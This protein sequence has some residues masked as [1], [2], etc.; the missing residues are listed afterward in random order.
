MIFLLNTRQRSPRSSRRSNPI[1]PNPSVSKYLIVTY[2]NTYYSVQTPLET[3]KA[4]LEEQETKA[5][6]YVANRQNTLSA[7]QKNRKICEKYRAEVENKSTHSFLALDNLLTDIFYIAN[8]LQDLL[9]EQKRMR[10]II[11]EQNLSEE[12]IRRITNEEDQLRKTVTQLTEKLNEARK[13]LADLEVQV[14]R[15]SEEAEDLLFN[16]ETL[17]TECGLFVPG[18]P[19]PEPISHVKLEITLDTAKADPQT[20][21]NGADVRGVIRPALLAYR[22]AKA[23]EGVDVG[24]SND[25]L[26]AAIEKLQSET[27]EILERIR[28]HEDQRSQIEQSIETAKTVRTHV[29]CE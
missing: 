7:L 28:E 11:H 16:Y 22:S 14:T 1:G 21:I 25:D 9:A 29:R 27:D 8:E 12:D 6:A 23:A 24:S 15:K 19:P 2:S 4:Q 17:L 26:A 13:A 18:R 3:A 10:K 5:K 20:M